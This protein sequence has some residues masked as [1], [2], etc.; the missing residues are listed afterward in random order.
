MNKPRV[1]FG[2]D[3]QDQALWVLYCSSRPNGKI[4]RENSKKEPTAP[5]EDCLTLCCMFL[6]DFESY[7]GDGDTAVFHA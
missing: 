7:L 6:V 3:I 1:F 5:G 2:K 4:F